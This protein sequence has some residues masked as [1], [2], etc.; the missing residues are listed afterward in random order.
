MAN[1][2]RHTS[3][4][5]CSS[6]DAMAVYDD[7]SLHCFS[8]GY[9][10]RSLELEAE[11]ESNSLV[12]TRVRSI[13]KD[14][15]IMSSK[16]II[17]DERRAEIKANTSFDDTLYRGITQATRKF[18]NVRT[19]Y[20]EDGEV[21]KQ[22]YPVTQNG[23]TLTGY[24][25]RGTPKDFYSEGR[26]GKECDLFGQFRFKDTTGKYILI[27]GGEEDAQA[28][29]QMLKAYADSKG[30][31]FITP[32]VSPTIG[33]TGSNKQ[34]ATNYAFL[35]RFDTIILGFDNDKAGKEAMEKAISALPK[36]KIKIATWAMKDPNEM[37]LAGKAREFIKNFYDAKEYVPAGVV[38]SN[39]L[40]DKVKSQAIIQRVPFPPFLRKLQEMTLGLTLGH[41]YVCGA[42]T[43]VGK[44]TLVNEMIYYWIFNSPH[45]LGIVS[46]ELDSG[47]YGEAL[48]SRH[49]EV[50]LARKTPEEKISYLELDRTKELAEELFCKPDGSSRFWLVEDRDATTKQLQ[51]TIEEMV[52][53]AGVKIVVLDVIQDVIEGMSN[54]DQGLF[55][56]WCKNL[57]KSHGISL[58]LISHLRKKPQGAENPLEVTE[59]DIHGSSTIAK[60][61]SLIFLMARDKNAE[62]ET[63]KNTTYVTIP[64]NRITGDTGDAGKIFYDKYKHVMY[65]FD[66]YMGISVNSTVTDVVN[67]LDDKGEF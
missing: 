13:E 6:S 1:F 22:Y 52:I 28:S 36:G 2:V 12:R 51:A 56:K 9:T 50:K 18:Y 17:T 37:L 47:Q 20:D 21:I 64:K 66:E 29:Y 54:E 19:E 63:D 26:I 65:D 62:D 34:L 67:K 43:S 30:S 41:I 5:K 58:V 15:K 61:A 39:A 8:C 49:L 40:F 53:S 33:E 14:E 25:V 55:M 38:G 57:I 32:V 7:D 3:C 23:D 31:D 11:Q 27:V 60:S 42:G 46:M 45:L 4:V 35:D 48:L 10:K 44:T 24:K 59:H 16:E